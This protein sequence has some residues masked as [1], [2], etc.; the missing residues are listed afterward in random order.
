MVSRPGF[1][2]SDRAPR[3][4][5]LS[6]ARDAAALADR[7]GRERFAV[8]GVSAGGPYALACAHE[9]PDRVAAAAVVGGF[10]GAPSDLPRAARLGFCA[11][12]ARPA[13]CARAG[14]ALC[15]AARHHPRALAAL[16]RGRLADRPAAAR[17]GRDAGVRRGALPGGRMQRRRRHDRRRQ[18]LRSPV[19]VR[20]GRRPRARPSLA[21]RPGSARARRQ[22]DPPRGGTAPRAPGAAPRRGPLLLS[23]QVA[24]DPRRPRRRRSRPPRRR[25]RPTS[26]RRGCRPGRPGA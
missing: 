15:R 25:A 6:F 3:R 24:R 14:D 21:W 2:D 1:G 17:R 12:R 8:V 16:L 5:L 23:P 18:P 11:L 9:L 19:G 10:A 4:T 22:R 20:T 26:H 7:L 13:A